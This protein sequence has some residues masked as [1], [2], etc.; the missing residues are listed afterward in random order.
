LSSTGDDWLGA[1]VVA[2]P[3]AMVSAVLARCRESHATSPIT[4]LSAALIGGGGVLALV[5]AQH[6]CALVV[7]AVRGEA[8]DDVRPPWP[9]GMSA[10]SG[11]L[12]AAIANAATMFRI[13]MIASG[14]RTTPNE[15]QDAA[16]DAATQIRRTGTERRCGAKWRAS[17]RAA[18]GHVAVS[19]TEDARE[20]RTDVL[21]KALGNVT[22]VELPGAV[23][24][25]EL[26]HGIVI[27]S[28][29]SQQPNE[30]IPEHGGAY[31]QTIAITRMRGARDRTCVMPVLQQ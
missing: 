31:E 20:I 24:P 13:D 4:F 17:Q 1:G 12:R 29:F 27:V 30:D 7:A 5:R 26:Q 11:A 10:S 18:T 15:R 21:V 3:Q 9:S 14:R 6:A 25:K 19:D 22:E 8:C 16:G 23:G 28:A 2:L